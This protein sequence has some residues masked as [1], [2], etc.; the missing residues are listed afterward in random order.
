MIFPFKAEGQ[1]SRPSAWQKKGQNL[2]VLAL[3][4]TP[5]TVFTKS[6]MVPLVFQA[7][8]AAAQPGPPLGQTLLIINQFSRLPA[9]DLHPSGSAKPHGYLTLLHQHWNLPQP[10]GKLQ[11]FLQILGL[12]HHVPVSHAVTLFG[13]GLPGLLGKGSGGLPEDDDLLGHHA[14]LFQ[15]PT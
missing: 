11:H 8:G 7:S 1:T 2:L 14:L 13:L 10:L 9:G 6:R 3:K 5:L 4:V 15:L 12:G